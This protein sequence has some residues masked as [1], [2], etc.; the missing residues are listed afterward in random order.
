MFD[1]PDLDRCFVCGYDKPTMTIEEDGKN[2]LLT[3][4][5]YCLECASKLG[6]P[7]HDWAVEAE[8]RKKAKRKST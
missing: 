5:R 6:F 1:S 2:G 7:V 8:Q 4:R 3:V